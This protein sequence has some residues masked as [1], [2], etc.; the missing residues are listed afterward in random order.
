MPYKDPQSERAKRS[1]IERNNRYREK[2][3]E[4]YLESC[5]KSNAKRKEK[6]AEWHRTNANHY[7]NRTI[8]NW[9]RIGVIYDDYD[10]L[11]EEYNKETHCWICNKEFDKRNNR[12]LDHDHATGEPRYICCRGCNTKVIADWDKS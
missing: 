5:R 6:M 7:K 12:H 4:K 10:K 2:H 11:F 9:K 8:S 1:Q 3:K